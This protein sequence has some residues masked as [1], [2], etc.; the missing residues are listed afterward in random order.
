MNFFRRKSIFVLLI[1]VIVLVVF[2]G[3]S[4]LNKGNKSLPEKIV[5]DTVGSVQNVFNVPIEYVSQ[6]FSNISELKNTYNENKVLRKEL[7]E[8]KT[9]IYE[10][11]E[12]EK[13]NKELRR[14]VELE[15]SARDYNPINGN[16][17]SRSPERWLEFVT[18]NRGTK[19]GVKQ[20]MAVITV[21]GMIGKVQSVSNV[22]S[23]VQLITGF[24]QL[25]QIS[26]TVSRK[27][28]GNVFGLIEGYDAKEKAL[29]FRIIE[30]SGG[31]LKEGELVVSSNTGGL[32]PS[33]LPIGK[34]KE[35]NPDEYG[36]TK[37]ALVEPAANMSEINQVIVV[38]RLLETDEDGSDE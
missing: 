16:V 36:L 29:I 31:K 11:Q 6:F 13:E 37:I 34:I 12:L 3:Y 38:D 27:K 9:L 14:M 5:S 1:G 20:N 26:A 2:L 30:D 24:D 22:T 21:D 8:N 28:G 19:H 32:Y 17:I 35:V 18:I 4:A 23:T 10:L 33:G 25:N 7:A 15:D